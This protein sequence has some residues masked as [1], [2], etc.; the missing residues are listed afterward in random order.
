MNDHVTSAASTPSPPKSRRFWNWKL[1]GG[2][3]VLTV[4]GVYLF[5]AQAPR[6]PGMAG[7]V[8]GI[9]SIWL[10]LSEFRGFAVAPKAIS[11]PSR[12]V[13]L[14]I[15]SLRRMSVSPASVREL[16]VM[17][18]WF[19][20]QVVEIYGG[21]GTELLLFQSR[22]Q[23]LRFTSAVEAI[24]PN[25]NVFRQKPLPKEYELQ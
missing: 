22:G 14:P 7:L 10:L 19:S 13:K 5:L 25:A 11:F 20:F 16:T 18:T 6:L 24:C 17:Q 2:E 3:I 15:L 4:L 8:V 23:R 1:I 12:F 9:L 21:F